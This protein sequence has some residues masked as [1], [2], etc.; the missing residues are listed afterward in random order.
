MTKAT[1]SG[2]VSAHSNLEAFGGGTS[3][4]KDQAAASGRWARPQHLLAVVAVV[5]VLAAPPI[6]SC[7]TV[8]TNLL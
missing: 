3:V 8:A 6:A 7:I 4:L 2:G 1:L 5:A